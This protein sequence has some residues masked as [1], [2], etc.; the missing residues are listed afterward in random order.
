MRRRFAPAGKG[1]LSA[2]GITI[3]RLKQSVFNRE[4]EYVNWNHSAYR[5][6]FD[7][8]WGD[9][10]LAPQPRMGLRTQWGH[11]TGFADHYH[12]IGVGEDITR[13]SDFARQRT[14]NHR[15]KSYRLL[16]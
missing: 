12:F 2:T 15:S 13:C 5:F 10:D 8:Y 11:W 14:R 16:V 1:H 6:D 4:K 7:P 9:P 3:A